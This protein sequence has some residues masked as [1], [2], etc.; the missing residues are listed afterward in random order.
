M[1]DQHAKKDK[2]DENGEAKIFVR[3]EDE[4]KGKFRKKKMDVF[5]RR[6]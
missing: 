3:I 6:T 4:L 1:L 2:E 5:A